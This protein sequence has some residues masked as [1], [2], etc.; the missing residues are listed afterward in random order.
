M[1]RMHRLDHVRRQFPDSIVDF[2]D[3]FALCPQNWVAVLQDWQNHFSSL[4]KAGKFLTPAS[5][6][7]SMTLIIVPKE[8]FLSA[9][10]AS[11]DLRV[12]GKLRT[13]PSSS[14]TPIACP[15]NLS[16]S[17]WSMLTIACSA[18]AGCFFAVLDSG[19]LI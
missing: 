12:S 15:S 19:R 13:A 2:V 17:F 10:S 3:P 9:W 11:V 4:V 1:R 6:N 14:S 8:A 5:F 18:S 7:A 16:S